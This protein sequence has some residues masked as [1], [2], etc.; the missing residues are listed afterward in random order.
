MTC[1]YCGEEINGDYLAHG[2][3]PIKPQLYHPD[4]FTEMAAGPE[5]PAEEAERVLEEL[6][7]E[8]K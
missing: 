2:R 1:H 4:C 3:S 6:W 5:T 7:E 8:N